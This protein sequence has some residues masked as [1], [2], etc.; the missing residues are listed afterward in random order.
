MADHSERW[1]LNHLIEMCKDEESTL[2]LAESHVK[3][4]SVKALLAEVATQRARF[5]ADLRTHA[6]RLGGA[7]AA[8]STLGGALRRRWM[9]L[10][11][12]L[13]G[14]DDRGMLS[15]AEHAD[16][17]ALAAYEQTLN[18]MLPPTTRD[19]VERQC[20]EVRLTHDRVRALLLH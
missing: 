1:V 7:E 14:S 13:V 19:L 9:A 6:Q 18:G 5:A 8:D 11:D 20:Q 3:D 17:L 4:S 10:K 2:R 16:A 15:Q 12:M